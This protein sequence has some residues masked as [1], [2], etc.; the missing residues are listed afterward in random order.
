MGCLYMPD[1]KSPSLSE[2]VSQAL[3]LPEPEVRGLLHAGFHVDGPF[4]DRVAGTT[5]VDVQALRPFLGSSLS[6]FYAKA[7]CGTAH[8]GRPAKGKRGEMAV[9]MAFQ[10]ALAGVLL[11]VELVAARSALRRA[12]MRPL[13]KVDLLKDIGGPLQ[14]P[15][16]KHRSGRCICQDSFFVTEY[17][18]KYP[19][20]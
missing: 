16:A 6:A 5:G 10:S 19:D 20:A 7:V 2:R 18:R 11:A 15:A 4:L 12:M 17:G 3:Q 9:P 8:F 1:S 14:E 13:T